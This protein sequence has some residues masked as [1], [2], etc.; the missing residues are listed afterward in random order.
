MQHNNKQ[1]AIPD[2]ELVVFAQETLE[3]S[4]GKHPK[5]W[6]IM[7]VDDE[8]E[9]HAITRNVLDEL[10]FKGRGFTYVNAYSAQEAIQLFKANPDI[11]LILLDVVMENDHAGLDVVRY[12]RKELLN[13]FVRI[14][15][16]TGQPGR[17][18][19]RKV[20]MDY[21]IND[22]KIK[23]M[24]T[25]QGLYTAVI[26]AIRT[27][28]D[29]QV[30]EQQRMEL[31]RALEEAQIS[32]KARY[33]FLA[34]IGHELRTPLNHVLG[35]T[36][37]LLNTPVTSRQRDYLQ[38]MKKSGEELCKVIN[39][40]LELSELVEGHVVLKASLFSLRSIIEEIM[41]VMTIQARWKNLQTAYHV[42][43]DLPDH[44]IGDEKRIKQILINVIGN[45]IKYTQQ[46]SIEVDVAPHPDQS[47][48]IL[49]I[50]KDT[51]MGIAKDKQ[52]YIFQ[53]FE[54]GE[55]IL[56]KEFS[57]AGLGLAI[58][59]GLVDKMNGSIWFESQSGHGSTFYVSLPFNTA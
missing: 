46:G 22:Y 55:D 32:N 58:S 24:L 47:H 1:A 54:L 30:I 44:L 17:A 31:A 19:E 21:D 20:I 42:A 40:V 18:P 33:Q 8:E 35:F 50:V 15:L 3:S 28:W 41:D 38:K 43:S 53:P 45:A 26:S 39:N 59:K 2:D 57:G 48:H 9:V 34:N 4:M 27:F 11:A 6:K 10:S 36:E 16:Y 13:K 56:R 5:P 25:S 7:I 23:S 49:F 51:G 14:I 52:E 29:I 37:V 12:I